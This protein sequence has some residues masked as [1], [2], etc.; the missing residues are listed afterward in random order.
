M[1]GSNN[2]NRRKNI[3]VIQGKINKGFQNSINKITESD[4][5]ALGF[6]VYQF[7]IN[8]SNAFL[9]NISKQGLTDCFG[10][11]STWLLQK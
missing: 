6:V 5:V 8:I 7:T 2:L 9:Y 10:I 1:E 4:L 3:I 11:T